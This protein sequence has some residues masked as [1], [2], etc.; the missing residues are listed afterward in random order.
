[1]V[2]FKGTCT[3]NPYISWKKDRISCKFFKL[4]P[5]FFNKMGLFFLPGP[6]HWTFHE[7]RLLSIRVPWI[8]W[9]SLGGAIFLILGRFCEDF[10]GFCKDFGNFG[11]IWKSRI[12]TGRCWKLAS[13]ELDLMIWL[14]SACIHQLATGGSRVSFSQELWPCLPCSGPSGAMLHHRHCLLVR[15]STK[16]WG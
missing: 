9:R 7:H 1:M 11:W 15:S 14:A 4:I 16:T 12:V 2:W 10:G 5:D 8:A 3:G 6:G 13:F